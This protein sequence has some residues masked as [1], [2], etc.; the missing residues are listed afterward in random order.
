MDWAEAFLAGLIV[1]AV[2]T[3]AGVS[4]AVLLLP[5]QVSVLGVPSP[6]VTPTNL[7]YNLFATPS[8][9]LRYRRRGGLQSSLAG[10]LIAGTLPGVVIGAVIRVE[11][12]SG[13]RGFLLVVA[14]VLIPLGVL[15]LVRKPPQADHPILPIGSLAPLAFGVGV[16]G[17]I[18]GIG[19]GSILAPI[20]LLAGY[21]AYQV[22]PAA[23]LSTMA[24]SI[25]GLIAYLVLASTEPGGSI[26]PDWGIGIAAG[27]GGTVG[28]YA[29]ASVQ[30]RIPEAALRRLLGVVVIAI[31]IRY[32]FIAL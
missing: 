11:W 17:G 31:G 32:A 2:T 16:I 22:A 9:V 7:I 30:P 15:L 26:A 3:P 24:A 13:E 23:L 14:A 5:V 27:L 29:G 4:G 25:V 8:G 19:G 28:A 1:A 12:L 18:Y 6:A 21:S 10:R 20:L